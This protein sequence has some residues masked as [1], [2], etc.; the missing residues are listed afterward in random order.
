MSGGSRLHVLLC[1]LFNLFIKFGYVPPAFHSAVIV[2]LVTCKT[3][4]ITD[5]NNYRAIAISNAITTRMWANAQRDGLP[6]ENRWRPLFNAA[7][8]S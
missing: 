2:P 7:K 8:F 1:V 3:G 4:D 6:T 5:V